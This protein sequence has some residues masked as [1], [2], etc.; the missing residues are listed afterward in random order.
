MPKKSVKMISAFLALLMAAM[1]C[2]MPVMRPAVPTGVA[3][4]VAPSATPAP[5][6]PLPT[7]IPFTP[8]PGQ[9]WTIYQDTDWNFS[10]NLPNLIKEK[11]ILLVKKRSSIPMG[12]E[13]LLLLSDSSQSGIQTSGLDESIRVV[14]FRSK[15]DGATPFDLWATLM[16]T[17]VGKGKLTEAQNGSC[18]QISIVA[19]KPIQPYEW[20][21]ANWV[22]AGDYYF[23]IMINGKGT[24]PAE[25]ETIL[26]SFQPEKCK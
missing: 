26:K 17:N 16:S 15:P 23:G 9:V 25:I 14:I 7:P 4:S 5:P 8:T 1:S 13:I 22:N 24:S 3:P 12:P 21:S 19:E 18:T 2:N 10:V 20:A 11:Q 6:T